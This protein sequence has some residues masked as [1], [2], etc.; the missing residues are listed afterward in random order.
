MTTS[1][2]EFLENPIQDSDSYSNFYDWFCKKSS[3]ENKMLKAV[4]VIKFLV[5]ENIINPDTSYVWLKN[6]C[7]VNGVLY[8]DIRF[9]TFDLEERY[10][11][12]ICPK[13][14]HYNEDK[15]CSIWGFDSERNIIEF[16]FDNLKTFKKELKEDPT[17]KGKLQNLFK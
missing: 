14:G 3:L 10:L 17:L 6:N 15:K 13:S 9:S 11:G 2:R 16:K 4:P 1:I 12:G 5:K 7:P 8:D